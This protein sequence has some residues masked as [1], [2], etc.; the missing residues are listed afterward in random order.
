MVSGRHVAEIVSRGY[1]FMWSANTVFRARSA[2]RPHSLAVVYAPAGVLATSVPPPVAVV[3]QSTQAH[4]GRSP[5]PVGRGDVGDV[6]GVWLSCS[7]HALTRS[8]AITH[9]RSRIRSLLFRSIR[10]GGALS[11]T[12]QALANRVAGIPYQRGQR[13]FAERKTL[14]VLGVRVVRLE[15]IEPP[16]LRFEV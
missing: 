12:G 1:F 2:C 11:G 8:D 3:N 10:H 4:W 16:T 6:T 13:P 9:R 15:G 7:E 5:C 14:V